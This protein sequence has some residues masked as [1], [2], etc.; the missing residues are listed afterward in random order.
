M[1]IISRSPEET[2]SI[3]E[4]I[5]QALAPGDILALEGDLGTG[6]T[7]LTKG[8]AKGL[9]V[10]SEDVVTSPT[11]TLI[12]EYR[13]RGGLPI[14]HFDIYRLDG[15]RDL[16]DLGYEEYFYGEGVTI[17]EWADK[18]A[19]LIPPSAFRI[20]LSFVEGADTHRR[21]TLPPELDI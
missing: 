18:I 11:F 21:I 14:Y 2:L 3:G 9:G 16:V 20:E 7:V 4:R 12:N 17:I 8:I 13:G 5:G 10:D 15:P 6:K 1:V 19:P